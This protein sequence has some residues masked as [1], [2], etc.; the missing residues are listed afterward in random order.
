MRA[1]AILVLI[2]A[3]A[4]A[5]RKSAETY[6]RAGEKAYK[7]QNFDA[8]AANFDRAG[9]AITRANRTEHSASGNR[10]RSPARHRRSI[11]QLAISVS[12]PTIC[13]SSRRQRATVSIAGADGTQTRVCAQDRQLNRRGDVADPLALRSHC[14]VWCL[15]AL[16][17]WQP[18]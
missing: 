7:A 1:L 6:F 12:A 2:A 11:A 9:V 14:D 13:L 10:S 17:R 16:R 5:D 3:T 15:R 18:K 8:A 4:H